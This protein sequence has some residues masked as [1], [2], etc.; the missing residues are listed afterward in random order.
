MAAGQRSGD[1]NLRILEAFLSGTPVQELA[2]RFH[3]SRE[4]VE[5]GHAVG[6][7]HVAHDDGRIAVEMLAKEPRRQ[8]A[9]RFD[10]A[11]AQVQ[12]LTRECS[13]LIRLALN[14]FDSTD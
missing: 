1:R 8:P 10:E 5:R 6:A 2:D 13:A 12:L 7:R 4:M 3:L 9:A 11:L 14:L